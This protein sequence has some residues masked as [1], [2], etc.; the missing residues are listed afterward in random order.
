MN[1]PGKNEIPHP[2]LLDMSQTLK[3]RAIDE[4]LDPS[5]FD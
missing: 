3:I 4:R 1:C 2:Q 5:I